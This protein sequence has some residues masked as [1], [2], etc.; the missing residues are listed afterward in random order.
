MY[1]FTREERMAAARRP[2]RAFS[3]AAPGAKNG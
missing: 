3:G 1:K 2:L